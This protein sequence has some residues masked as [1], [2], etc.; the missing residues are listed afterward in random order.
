[1]NEVVG[2]EVRTA[3]HDVQAPHS[4]LSDRRVCAQP[5]QR[6]AGDHSTQGPLPEV[7]LSH[8]TTSNRYTVWALDI[9]IDSFDHSAPLCTV[10]NAGREM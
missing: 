2:H 4:T 9:K 8:S 7:M 5:A 3:W 1:M 6:Q 10:D